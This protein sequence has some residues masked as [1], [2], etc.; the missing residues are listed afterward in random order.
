MAGVPVWAQTGRN[1]GWALTEDYRTDLTG[2]TESELRSLVVAG[3]PG[4]LSGLGLGEAFDRA[5]TK[6]LA[7]LPAARRETATAARG[8]LHVDP[9]GWRRTED[10]APVAADPRRRAAPRTPGDHRVRAGLRPDRR[11]AHGRPRRARR[12]GLGLV[13]G[14]A[15][16]TARRGRTARRAS[17]RVDVLDDAAANDRP[18]S[19]LPRTGPSA[20]DVV[21]GR[22]AGDRLGDA[23]LAPGHRPDPAGL[24]LRP[25]RRR[26]PAR[27]RRL[28]HGALPRRLDRGRG[29]VRARS[30]GGRRGRSARPT[31]RLGS[32]AGARGRRGPRG[33]TRR[34]ARMS[35]YDVAG[36]AAP[37]DPGRAGRAEP[38]RRLRR[39]GRR[40]QRRD[41]GP[42]PAPRWRADRRPLRRRPAVRLPR[43]PPD[44]A[45]RRRPAVGDDLAGAGHQAG[46]RRRPRP[47][48]PGRPGA[49]RS[50]AGLQR[51]AGRAGPPLRRPGVDQP[52]QHPGRRPAHPRGAHPGDRV[53]AR[54]PARRRPGRSVRDAARAGRRRVRAGDGHGRGR[55]P[56]RRLLRPGPALRVRAPTRRRRSPCSAPSAGTSG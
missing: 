2:L 41:D 9:S 7:T 20:R 17:A 19:T 24:A 51:G 1:G 38:R 18:T 14:R 15:R 54:P 50:L 8:Y 31:S 16:S 55:H 26:G 36:P 5:I 56:G 37:G 23:L 22:P 42:R 48:R 46:P 52:G 45:H 35:L 13:P 32:C 39:L 3:A 49:G 29:R 6:V 12:Q 27:P 10:A 33:T 21:P 34:L 40:G 25:A 4:V 30:R 53:A 43:P 47:A 11:G 28:G 44:A